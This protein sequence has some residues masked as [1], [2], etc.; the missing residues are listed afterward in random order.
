[1]LQL[2]RTKVLIA[3]LVFA[4]GVAF[5][6]VKPAEFDFGKHEYDANCASC[7]GPTGKGDGPNRPYLDKS[8]SDLSTLSK[9]NEGLFPYEHVYE[10]VDGRQVV[11]EPSQREMPCW[12]AVYLEK[13]A[14]DYLDVPYQPEA[15]VETRLVALIGHLK[16]LQ[17]N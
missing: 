5:G 6:Q 12:G 1:M 17:V 10:V 2:I 16:G 8:P 3:A 4:S 7:H 14:G 11:A 13:A 9:R 15:Y